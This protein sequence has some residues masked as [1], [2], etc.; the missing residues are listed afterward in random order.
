M[1]L[2]STLNK[3]YIIDNVW[4]KDY[5]LRDR[6]ESP[7]HKEKALFLEHRREEKQHGESRE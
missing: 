1:T 7:P 6:A 5:S 4:E 3:V 2:L